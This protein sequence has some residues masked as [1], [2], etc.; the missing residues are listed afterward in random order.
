MEKFFGEHNSYSGQRSSK[1]IQ[2]DVKKIIYVSPENFYTKPKVDSSIIELS[3]KSN[4]NFNYENIDELLK[5][6]FAQRRKKLKNNLNKISH[7]NLQKII[8]SGV[9]LNLRPQNISIDNYLMMS[10]LLF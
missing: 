6:C 2:K 4:L 7:S 3:P 5:I 9:D 8:N 10:K 1:S